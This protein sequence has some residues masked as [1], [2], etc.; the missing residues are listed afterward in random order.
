M[1]PRKIV[2]DT[3]SFSSPE[4]IPRQLWAL[5]WAH[6]HYPLELTAIRRDYPDD[7]VGSPAFLQTSPQTAGDPYAIGSYTDEWGC[8][9]TNIQAGVIGEVKKPLLETYSDLD[10]LRTPDELL[11]VDIDQVNAFCR[12]TDHFVMAGGGA[13]PFERIQYIRRSENLYMDLIDYRQDVLTLLNKVHEFDLKLFDIWTQTE[14]DA[15]SWNDDWGAQ[16]ALLISPELWRSIFKPIYKDYIDLAHSRG[17]YAFM[18]SDGYIADIIPDLIELGLD[19]LN[20]QLFCMNIEDLGRKFGGKLTFW[21]EID[22]Q[23]LLPF[24]TPQQ[25]DAAVHRVHSALYKSGGA[26]A[27]CEFSAGSKPENVAQVFRSW[28]L[29]SQGS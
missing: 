10:H 17:K 6:I 11:S 24:A 20:S 2:K 3:L 8:C 16:K 25:I 7:I 21:G 9:F 27:Q 1:H 18:H 28:D 22:R 23:Y 14:V 15:I 13:Q 26:I 5:P 12:S 29:L 19:A 4:R